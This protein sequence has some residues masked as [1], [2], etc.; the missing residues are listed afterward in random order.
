MA[1]PKAT[2]SLAGD[3]RAA[4]RPSSRARNGLSV[5]FTFLRSWVPYPPFAGKLPF[6]IVLPD[7]PPRKCGHPHARMRRLTAA[8]GCTP[9]LRPHDRARGTSVTAVESAGK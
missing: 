6:A 2:H 9:L 5:L 7:R 8:A 4:R 3:R 1:I